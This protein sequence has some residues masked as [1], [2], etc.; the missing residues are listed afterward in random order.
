[1]LPKNIIQQE[2]IDVFLVME[3]TPSEINFPKYFDIMNIWLR[4]IRRY[5]EYLDLTAWCCKFS[6][7]LHKLYNRFL[8]YKN[9]FLKSGRDEVGCTC[10]WPTSG[11]ARSIMLTKLYIFCSISRNHFKKLIVH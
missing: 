7:V 9:H 4:N 10:H 11:R 1:M 6:Y 5:L 8:C 3:G 2:K